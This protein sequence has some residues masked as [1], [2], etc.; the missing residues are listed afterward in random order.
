[1]VRRGLPAVGPEGLDD[2][3][4]AIDPAGRITQLRSER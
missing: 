4:Q 1:M 3:Q 2:M